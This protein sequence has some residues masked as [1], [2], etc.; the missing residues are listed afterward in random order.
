MENKCSPD[1]LFAVPLKLPRNPQHCSKTKKTQ[2]TSA[3]ISHEQTKGD[4]LQISISYG[5]LPRSFLRKNK[6][7]EKR[8]YSQYSLSKW[9]K[10]TA[11]WGAAH[12]AMQSR[13]PVWTQKQCCKWKL[14]PSRRKVC[15]GATNSLLTGLRGQRS[16]IHCRSHWQLLILITG[17]LITA[18]YHHQFPPWI[19]SPQQHGREKGEMPEPK[20]W[21]GDA[22]ETLSR[23]LSSTNPRVI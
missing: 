4:Y 8:L 7:I 14:F 1:S 20:V 6:I 17:N 21:L 5:C 15:T 19:R 23:G 22:V 12:S 10:Q 18:L 11:T 2:K 3:W 16:I 9:K 13:Q